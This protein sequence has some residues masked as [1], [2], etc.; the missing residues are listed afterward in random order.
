MSD[1]FVLLVE[2][3][4]DELV[5]KNL[6]CWKIFFNFWYLMGKTTNC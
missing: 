2:G 1:K 6:L 3:K 4:D 5:I